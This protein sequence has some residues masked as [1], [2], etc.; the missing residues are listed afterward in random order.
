MRRKATKAFTLVEL[1]IVIIIIGILA[2]MT[3]LSAGSA[4]DS[5][6][7]AEC[8]AD[9]RSIKSAL[10]VYRAEDGSYTLTNDKLREILETRFDNF[11]GT[12][13]DTGTKITGIC[14]ASGDYTVAISD[15][16]VTIT[17]SVAEHNVSSESAGTAAKSNEDIITALAGVPSSASSAKA[18]I[19]EYFSKKSDGTYLDSNINSSDADKIT[20]LLEQSLGI[21]LDGYNW[22]AIKFS[23]S[24]TVYLTSQDLSKLKAGDEITVTKYE[25]STGNTS[26]VTTK[27]GTTTYNG[28]T[29]NVIEHVATSNGQIRNRP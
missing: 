8:I 10:Y 5:A 22:M 16:K 9:R 14:P 27:V 18:A 6:K 7:K 17:C 11:R 2:G 26:T 13:S 19:E 25:T 3:M 20:K 4:I 12:V 15:D 24:Y 1:L 29:Y 21:S 28:V 23:S